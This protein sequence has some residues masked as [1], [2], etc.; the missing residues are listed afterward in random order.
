MNNM[1]KIFQYLLYFLYNIYINY[2]LQN[3]YIKYMFSFILT[4]LFKVLYV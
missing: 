3:R 1:D 2:R 4:V